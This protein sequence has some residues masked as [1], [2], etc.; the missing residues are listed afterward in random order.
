MATCLIG[1][2]FLVSYQITKPSY[3]SITPEELSNLISSSSVVLVDIR[4][5]EEY[6]SGHIPNTEYNI[7]VKYDSFLDKANLL[8]D[9]DTPVALYCRSGN[10]SK[11]AAKTLS[12]MGYNVVELDGGYNDWVKSYGD[13]K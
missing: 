12:M 4:T 6:E 11:N 9:K 1:I 7:D 10:R 3:N 2:V 5:Q 8:L 13:V